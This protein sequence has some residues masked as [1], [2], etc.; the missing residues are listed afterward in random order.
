[1]PE[2]KTALIQLL[3]TANKQDNIKKAVEYISIAAKNNAKVISLPVLDILIEKY[4]KKNTLTQTVY[5]SEGMF[6]FPVRCKI[7]SRVL[8]AHTGR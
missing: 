1:M 5:L 3:V 2:F 6:Q 8:G 4:S 7:L